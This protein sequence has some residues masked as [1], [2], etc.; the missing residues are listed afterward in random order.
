MTPRIHTPEPSRDAYPAAGWK[1]P[2]EWPAKINF[3]FRNRAERLRR[4]CFR[5][6]VDFQNRG[7]LHFTILWENPLVIYAASPSVHRLLPLPRGSLV[8]I[9]LYDSLEFPPALNRMLAYLR[10]HFP[11][12]GPVTMMVL[13]NTP[14]EAEL[15]ESARVPAVCVNHNAFVDD[16]VFAIRPGIPKRYDAIYDAQISPYKRHY[17]AT[18]VKSLALISYLNHPSPEM[19]YAREMRQR[20][21]EAT[22][23]NDPLSSAFRRLGLTEV[24][25][26]T[27][28]ARVGLCLSESEGAMYASC[29][30]LLCGLPVV[31]TPS[32]GGRDFFFEPD[33][34]LVVDPTPAAVAAGVNIMA[35]RRLSPE[36]IRSRTLARM[37]ELR[38][39]FISII[40]AHLVASGTK[41]D[42]AGH[43]EHIFF[44]TLLKVRYARR[45]LAK[46]ARS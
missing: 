27:S 31:T 20:L 12:G 3:F 24:A 25:E 6:V 23:L 2:A 4:Q 8:L 45:E 10:R 30:Y 37:R 41:V 36:S 5:Q 15:L 33:F 17:L 39:R 1:S 29:Q 26:A 28:A 16:R 9:A 21:G 35:E 11:A 18:D 14:R 44:H 13:T 19:A 42:F 38:G 40:Q 46:I 34:A 22:W 32:L 7:R 43:F